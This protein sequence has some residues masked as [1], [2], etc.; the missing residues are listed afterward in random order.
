[1]S[2]VARAAGVSRVT[3]SKILNDP[4]AGSVASRRRVLAAC[5]RLDYVPS[6]PARQLVSGAS[7]TVGLVVASLTN[8]FY[9]AIVEAAEAQARRLGHELVYRCSSGDAEAEARI[10]RHFLSLDVRAVLAT[11]VVSEANRPQWLRLRRRVPV[12]FIDHRLEPDDPCVIADHRAGAIAATRHLLAEGAVPALLESPAPARHAAVLGR[13]AGYLAAMRAARRPPRFI[14]GDAA[15]SPERYAHA[16]VARALATGPAPSGLFCTND[17]QALGAL[18]ALHERGLVVGRDVLLV[19]YDDQPFA[20]F[21]V[22]SLTSVRQP[23]AEL[24]ARAVRL[25]L[26]GEPGTGRGL[27]PVELIVRESSRRR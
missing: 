7:R 16:A 20:P 2:D 14:A 22:P 1:M 9:G 24:G 5:E 8:P 19:G 27:L 17:L 25:G 11:P 4:A 6:L 18:R 15:P 10:L 13:R 23:T 12:V 26:G 21:T 3:T